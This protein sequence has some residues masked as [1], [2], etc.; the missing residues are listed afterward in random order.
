MSGLGCKAERKIDRR[1]VLGKQRGV[2]GLVL[3]AAPLF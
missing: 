1:I 3:K 2:S